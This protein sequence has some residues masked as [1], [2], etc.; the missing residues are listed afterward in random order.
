MTKIR[1]AGQSSTLGI[2]IAQP[3]IE[4]RSLQLAEIE[5]CLLAKIQ[6]PDSALA[7]AMCPGTNHRELIS[8]NGTIARFVSY[9]IDHVQRRFR[10]DV[11][12]AADVQNGNSDIVERITAD[13]TLFPVVIEDRVFDPVFQIKHFFLELVV[14]VGS[15]GGT[16]TLRQCDPP[17]IGAPPTEEPQCM[18]NAS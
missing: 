15:G 11:V 3:V 5:G 8:S 12:P 10:E 13:T 17:G 2:L 4:P 14:E 16:E 1:N 6:L 7:D 18:S 9:A